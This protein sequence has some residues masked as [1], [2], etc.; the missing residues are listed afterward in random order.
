MCKL[1]QDTHWNDIDYMDNYDDFTV[2]NN[3]N[4]LPEYVNDLHKVISI[5]SLLLITK[6]TDNR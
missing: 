1:F 2:S 6:I 5:Q 3:F 4:K